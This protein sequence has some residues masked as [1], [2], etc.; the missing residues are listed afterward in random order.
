M[1]SALFYHCSD[2]KPQVAA[3]TTYNM[4]VMLGEMLALG[5]LNCPKYV[6]VVP[7]TPP[8]GWKKGVFWFHSLHATQV[9][10]VLVCA[11]YRVCIVCACHL[12]A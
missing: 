6:Y 7:D 3:V 9:R 5:E 8:G 1:L 2:Y 12:C 10:L 4:E 11:R